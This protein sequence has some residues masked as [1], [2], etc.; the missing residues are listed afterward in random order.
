[1]KRQES[2]EDYLETILILRS[3]LASVR[4]ID[5]AN[6]MGFSKPSVSIAMKKL[7]EKNLIIVDSDG[8]ITLTNEGLGI[9]EC[10]YERH[11]MLTE[12]LIRIG[13]DE[14]TAAE[15]ACKIEH[16]ISAQTFEKIKAH[17]KGSHIVTNE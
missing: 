13:V 5:I 1:M 3:T 15:D 11:R 2:T 9:A 14:A 6:D 7:R 17:V 4:S 10:I 16:D 12:F 8:H